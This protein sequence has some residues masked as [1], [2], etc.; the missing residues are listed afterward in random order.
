MNETQII[1]EPSA[2]THWKNLFPKKSALLGSH[3]LNEGEELV[4]CIASVG[5]QKIKDKNGKDE[6]VPVITFDNAPPMVVNI[7]NSR[8]IASL[9]GDL[10]EGWIGKSIQLFATEVKAFGEVTKAL[11][12]RTVIP[13]TN[14]DLTDF[15]TILKDCK[16]MDELKSSFMNLPKHIKPR[17]VDLKDKVKDEINARG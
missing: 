17:L 7:T 10:Y 11:R 16:T 3:N 8:A 6:E 13:D 14:E 2:T 15:E 12:V 5:I 9:Y 1:Y 4:A